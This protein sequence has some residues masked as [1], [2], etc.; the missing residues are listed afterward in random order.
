MAVGRKKL[1]FIKPKNHLHNQVDRPIG[2]SSS[3]RTRIFPLCMLAFILAVTGIYL[4]RPLFDP[5]FY[6]H[7]KTGQLIWE[8]KELPTIDFFG[9]L[10]LPDPTPRVKFTLTSYWLFQLLLYAFFSAGGMTGIIILRWLLA[11]IVLM[12]CARWS[13]LRNGYVLTALALVSIE[14]LE[15]F[16]LER[17][18]FFSFIAFGML[19]SILFTFSQQKKHW[20]LL[21]LLIPLSLLMLVWANMH[22]GYLAGVGILLLFCTLEGIKF[23]RPTFAPLAWR[24]YRL[25]LISTTAA[26]VASFVSPHPFLEFKDLMLFSAGNAQSPMQFREHLSIIAY[27]K[28]GLDYTPLFY[29]V[30]MA[31][32]AVA[33]LTSQHRKNLTWLG[34]ISATGF[35]GFVYIRYAPFFLIASAM[36]LMRYC[37][38]ERRAGVMGKLLFAAVMG[39]F[40]MGIRDEM[41]RIQEI[42]QSG[43]VPA[44]VYPVRAAEHLASY[45]TAGE[46]IYSLDFWGS[47]LIWR[48]GP[49][50][51]IFEDGRHL[52][53]ERTAEFIKAYRDSRE[54][55]AA[56]PYWK[57]LFQRYRIDVAVLPLN[58]ERGQLPL[59]TQ[60]ISIDPEWVLV[61]SDSMAAVFRRKP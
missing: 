32:T 30:S 10:P 60:S 13:N 9:V 41:S 43:W 2:N 52:Y 59:L 23:L 48:L 6:W 11:G 33:L 19:L 26:I 39:I 12:I 46:N 7:L 25:L 28:L 55:I 61:Y 42:R 47:Y 50:K 53:P 24:D 45:G 35:F 15:H 16:F 54:H 58:D 51:R 27:L 29:L 22:G 8:H 57:K 4:S 14:I 38:E 5:D 37:E 31:L 36:F 34:I 21:E 17:P 20:R 49:N 1:N 3:M 56:P 40:I 18:Q 44:S